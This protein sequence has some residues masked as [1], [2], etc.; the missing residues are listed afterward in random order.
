MLLL[1]KAIIFLVSDHKEKAADRRCIFASLINTYTAVGLSPCGEGKWRNANGQLAAKRI[2]LFYEYFPDLVNLNLDSYSICSIHY[3]Q[4]V[5]NNQFYE[6]LVG[7]TQ[8]NQPSRPGTNEGNLSINTTDPIVNLD[9][10]KQFVD[11]A[12]LENQQKSELIMELNG[13][14]ERMQQHIDDQENEIEELRSKLRRA[15]D[16]MAEIQDLCDEKIKHNG[17]LVEQWNSR[18][19][20]RQKWI[21]SVI[22]IAKAGQYNTKYVF[23]FFILI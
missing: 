22:K 21:N 23:F 7:S 11:S 5:I 8:E 18:F 13:R 14:I 10:I 16:N 2:R 6:H 3:N 1:T 12:R 19:S 15:Y 20:D 9:R 17:A 4:I